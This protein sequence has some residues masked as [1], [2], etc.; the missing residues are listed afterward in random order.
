[1]GILSQE[2]VKSNSPRRFCVECGAEAV[3]EVVHITDTG[4]GQRVFGMCAACLAEEYI[5]TDIPRRSLK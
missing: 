4:P 1:M 3:H 2:S 5:P